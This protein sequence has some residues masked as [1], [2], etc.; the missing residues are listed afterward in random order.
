VHGGAKY[1]CIHQGSEKA[2]QKA[3]A[4]KSPDARRAHPAQALELRLLQKDVAVQIGVSED[5]IIGWENA[6]SVPQIH[7]YPPIITFLAYYP[8]EK[9]L[10]CVSGQIELIRH[11]NGWSFERLAGEFNVH[12]TT[13]QNWYKKNALFA[14]IHKRILST[15]LQQCL[16]K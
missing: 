5:S 6:R 14:K 15:L 9:A 13:M 7:L 16:S 2:A 10:T 12:A 1:T 8:F 11:S 3:I 4:R